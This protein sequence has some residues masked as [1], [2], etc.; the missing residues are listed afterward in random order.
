MTKRA[1]KKKNRQLTTAET[2]V[3]QDGSQS[4]SLSETSTWWAALK[5]NVVDKAKETGG[6]LA[7]LVKTSREARLEMMAIK[8]RWPIPPDLKASMIFEAAAI[9]TNPKADPRNKVNA[10]RLLMTMEAMNQRDEKPDQAQITVVNGTQIVQA[11]IPDMLSQF[12]QQ[13]ASEDPKADPYYVEPG[14][15]DDY[16]E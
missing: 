6:G 5:P 4:G 13:W 2:I 7:D 15:E 10:S 3:Q 12:R 14:S 9:V 1:G 8:N 11:C 16:A